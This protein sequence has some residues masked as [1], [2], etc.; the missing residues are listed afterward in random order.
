MEEA[1]PKL[2]GGENDVLSIKVKDQQG[3][4]LA[5]KIK[6][7]TKLSKVKEAFC[8]NKGLDPNHVRFMFDDHRIAHDET[9]NDLDIEND[10][11]SAIEPLIYP[12]YLIHAHIT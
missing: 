7:N 5:F 3:G 11:V 10:D 4:E 8:K 6:R 12:I 2:E 9:P 1:K